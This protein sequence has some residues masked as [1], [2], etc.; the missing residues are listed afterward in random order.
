MSTFVRSSA[1]SLYSVGLRRVLVDNLSRFD[2]MYNK[3][4]STS[5]SMKKDEQD[6]S[7][8]GI[9]DI[10]QISENQNYPESQVNAGYTKTYTHNEFALILKY[11]QVAK[12]DELYGFLNKMGSFL[13]NAMRE[14]IEVSGAG[15][16][17][18]I[19]STAGPDGVNLLAT[20]H[21]CIDGTQSNSAGAVDLTYASLSDA[22]VAILGRK[23]W[24]NHPVTTPDK[25]LL[26]HSPTLDPQVAKLLKT[27][28]ESFSGDNTVNYVQGMF[29]PVCIPWMTDTNMWL[30]FE[31][32]NDD[33]C[34]WFWRVKP[35]VKTFVDDNND[36]TAI[37]IR[38]RWSNG[39]TDFRRSIIYGSAGSS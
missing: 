22:R 28:G 38:A 15:I 14:T 30:I 29:E 5:S 37:R 2:W 12:E 6:Y 8:F 27:S 21:P 35:S 7:M 32:P 34:K 36:A 9:Y 39:I 20:T 24:E 13:T 25:L 1:S 26:L 16:L 23:N 11:G 10:P 17:N 19:A 4:C 18:D 31:K 33:G 3:Y